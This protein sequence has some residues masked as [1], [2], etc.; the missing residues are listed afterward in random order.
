MGSDE[1]T[2]GKYTVENG[3]EKEQKFLRRNQRWR[4]I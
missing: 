2:A 1:K 4:D 3:K